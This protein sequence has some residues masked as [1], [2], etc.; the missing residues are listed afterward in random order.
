MCIRDSYMTDKSRAA[1]EALVQPFLPEAS[2]R[3]GYE[4]QVSPPHVLTH[5]ENGKVME[6]MERVVV[7]LSLIHI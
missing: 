1:A 3:E 2:R 4:L 6:P 7:D 5:E